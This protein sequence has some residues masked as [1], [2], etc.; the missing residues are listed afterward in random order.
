MGRIAAVL[1]LADTVYVMEFK[2]R[3]CDPDASAEV[4]DELFK[5]AL[6]EGE[7]QITDRGYADRYAGSGKEVIR[8]AFAFLGRDN[9]GMRIIP[10]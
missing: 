8:A 6:D 1:E 3:A 7:K 5:K 2:Y 9:I 4:K 10:G